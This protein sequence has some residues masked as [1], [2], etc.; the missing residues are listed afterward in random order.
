MEYFGSLPY[1]YYIIPITTLKLGLINPIKVRVKK[2]VK[3]VFFR[4]R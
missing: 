4:N 1:F 3:C 2:L